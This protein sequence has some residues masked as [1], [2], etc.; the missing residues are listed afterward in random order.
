[1]ASDKGQAPSKAGQYDLNQT[2]NYLGINN[3]EDLNKLVDQRKQEQQAPNEIGRYEKA[4]RDPLTL[5]RIGIPP[6]VEPTPVKPKGEVK[7]NHTVKESFLNALKSAENSIKAGY[8][9]AT[10][11]WFPHK[12][13]EGGEDTIGYGSK[14]NKNLVI[15]GQKVNPY[16][17]L[18]QDQV[19]KLFAL[20]V[21]KHLNLAKNQ[22]NK[23]SGTGFKF[24]QLDPRYQKVLANIAYNSGTLVNKNGQWGWPKLLKAIIKGDDQAVRKEMVTSYIDPKKGKVKLEARA[25]Q[26]ADALGIGKDI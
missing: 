9:K 21:D 16:K 2:L 25:Q 7:E 17:G 11:L 6:V 26:I 1:M 10:G 18:T 12:S 23:F 13:V 19:E 22:F 5:S 3:L 14:L 15:D 24:E 8:D 4:V 20:E